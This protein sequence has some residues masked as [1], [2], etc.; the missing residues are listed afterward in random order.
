MS[1][2]DARMTV[3][4][5]KD[6]FLPRS[7]TFIY[8]LL[9]SIKRY[10]SIVVDRHGRQNEALYPF[11]EHF[12]PV[13]RFGPWAGW[14]E[15]S[16]LRLLGRSPYIEH[17]LRAE[18]VRL[19]H[20]H[21]GQLGALFVP[22]ARRLAIPL[23]TSFYGK[24]L[25]T[26][27]TDP[28]WKS[29]FEALW[30][31]GQ[32]FL[33]LGPRMADRLKAL[34]C[35]AE[36]I[37]ILPIPIDLSQFHP[38][39]RRPP[40]P[41]EPTYI[42]TAGRLIPKKGVDILLRALASL[43]EMHRF[44][45]WIAGDGP[46]RTRLEGLVNELQ[47]QERVR[48]LGWRSHSEMIELMKNVHL[49]VLASRTDPKTGETE[50]TPTVLLEAQAMELPVVSTFHAD[51]PEIVRNGKTGFL[52]PEGDVAALSRILDELLRRRD[53]WMRI[54]RA[55]RAFLEAKHEMGKVGEQLEQ[56]YDDCIQ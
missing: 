36:R 22:V 42:L 54:G 53:A 8:T 52:V 3:A 11:K 15:R 41:N 26:F 55:G 13:E 45:L 10:R 25:S 2:L 46:E 30:A 56:I 48:F 16:A 38:P 49:F 24:D 27:A 9:R 7:E 21:F 20:A 34:G 31:Y 33:V 17:V 1:S 47:L 5:V 23:I 32:R 29:R 6:H 44:E 43:K 39:A 50:G 28:A 14:M 12:S 4:H 51:I 19:L 40:G 35:P 37:S 18:N